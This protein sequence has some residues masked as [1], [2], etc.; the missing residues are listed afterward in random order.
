MDDLYLPGIER[1][2]ADEL[3]WAVDRARA[4]EPTWITDEQGRAAEIVP[5][6]ILAE[7]DA[8]IARLTAALDEIRTWTAPGE[9]ETDAERAGRR[10][11]RDTQR[12]IADQEA[13]I[14][15]LK[16]EIDNLHGI[17]AEY[18]TTE[19]ALEAAMALPGREDGAVIREAGGQ[20][21]AWAWKAAAKEWEQVT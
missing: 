10:F 20:R 13:E 11:V 17:P 7:K 14:D 12:R 3:F 18:V 5:A 21:R 2:Y 8:E 9:G 19:A 1:M 16:A 15:R 6:S 4:G